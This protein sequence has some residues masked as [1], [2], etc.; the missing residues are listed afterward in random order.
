LW[1]TGLARLLNGTSIRGISG[2]GKE[3]KMDIYVGSLPYTITED[4]LKQAFQAF[5]SVE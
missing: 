3:R 5:G 4:E 2:K 1:E